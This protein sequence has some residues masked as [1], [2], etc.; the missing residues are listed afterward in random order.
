M[1]TRGPD[2]SLARPHDA[3]A[4]KSWSEERVDLQG[5]LAP[6][7]G[8]VESCVQA[9]VALS[10]ERRLLKLGLQTQK[11]PCSSEPLP[12]LRRRPCRL[13][14]GDRALN[15]SSSTNL[16]DSRFWPTKLHPMQHCPAGIESSVDSHD[17]STN[18]HQSLAP[19]SDSRSPAENFFANV[20]TSQA[21]PRLDGETKGRRSAGIEVLSTGLKIGL[22]LGTKF[23]AQ[24]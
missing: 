3:R 20:S 22:E 7:A 17:R 18:F 11:R 9:V 14:I 4:G 15:S 21:T 5:E 2:D 24:V 1:R 10:C 6:R 19:G 23:P 13:G 8:D 12:E 16:F